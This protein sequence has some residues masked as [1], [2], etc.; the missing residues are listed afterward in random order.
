MWGGGPTQDGLG[1]RVCVSVCPYSRKNTWI[2]TISRE[3]EPRDPTGL[4]ATG[5]LAMQK[6]F[7]K[8]NEAED[9]RSDWDGGKEAS[10]HNPPWWLRAENFLSI[11]KDWIYH[12]ME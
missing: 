6:N 1:C 9:Y 10:Y 7:F 12:G 2:H 4:V 5:L 11:E 3:M 8:F